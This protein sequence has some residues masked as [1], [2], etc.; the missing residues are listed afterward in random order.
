MSELIDMPSVVLVV[1]DL[2]RGGVQVGLQ[3]IQVEVQRFLM[4][5]DAERG[6]AFRS[7][8]DR[9]GERWECRG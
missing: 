8:P 3:V 6:G 5:R 4:E 9:A 1:V 2:E 7:A